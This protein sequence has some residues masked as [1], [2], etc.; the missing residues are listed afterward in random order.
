MKKIPHAAF[1]GESACLPVTD[2]PHAGQ[3]ALN[4]PVLLR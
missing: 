4:L 1:G 2:L 3:H